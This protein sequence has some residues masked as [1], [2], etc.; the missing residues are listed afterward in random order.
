MSTS[1]AP[2]CVHEEDLQGCCRECTPVAKTSI[3]VAHADAADLAKGNQLLC[4]GIAA[5]SDTMR[6][7]IEVMPE[8]I[9]IPK[10]LQTASLFTEG[11]AG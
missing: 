5:D 3:E 11:S 6:R 9:H 7:R 8:L 4:F 10:A 1:A 2:R